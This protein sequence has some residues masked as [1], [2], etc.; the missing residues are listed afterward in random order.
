MD[1][2][3]MVL[4]FRYLYWTDNGQ[5]P[6]IERAHLDGSNRKIIISNGIV[7]PLGITIDIKT[8]DVYW[9]DTR[10]DAI[11]VILFDIFLKKEHSF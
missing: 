3:T 10:V 2:K 11:Q 8:H 1:N 6:K 9:V 7:R 5:V 4:F